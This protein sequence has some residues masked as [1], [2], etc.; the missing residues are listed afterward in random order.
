MLAIRV[1]GYYQLYE[2]HFHPTKPTYNAQTFWR[3]Y[4]MSRKL[5]MTILNGMRAYD[6]Y[7]TAKPDATGKL[8]FTSYQKIFCNYSHACI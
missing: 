8:G 7:F 2:D 1:A 6:D 4:R 5:F 3:R